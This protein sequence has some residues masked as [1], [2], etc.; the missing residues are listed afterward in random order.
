MGAIRTDGMV[1]LCAESVAA[2][3]MMED[4]NAAIDDA[5]RDLVRRSQNLKSRKIT[6]VIELAPDKAAA[7]QDAPL[8]VPS[9][10]YSVSKAMPADAGTVT[11]ALLQPN[12]EMMVSAELPGEPEQRNIFEIKG[13]K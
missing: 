9:I 7:E 2:G 6:L 3:R 5:A 13:V 11:R 12:G 4:L 1:K 8:N 10:L